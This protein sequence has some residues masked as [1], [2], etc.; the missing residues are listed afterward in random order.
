MQRAAGR[1]GALARRRLSRYAHGHA[2]QAPCRPPPSYPEGR[3]P[4]PEL[5]GL[6]RRGDLTLRL[7]KAALTEWQ[8]PRR[9]TPGGQAWYPDAAIEPGPMLRLVFH[10]ALRQAEGLA[11]SMLR[12]L[13]QAPRVPDHIRLCRR[14]R[15]DRSRA[16]QSGHQTEAARPPLAGP[17]RRSRHGRRG[18]QPHDPGCGAGFHPRCCTQ[19]GGAVLSAHQTSVQQLCRERSPP[20]RPAGCPQPAREPAGCPE[21]GRPSQEEPHR[22]EDQARRTPQKAKTSEIGSVMVRR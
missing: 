20:S 4:V 18:A 6:K 5:A 12:L 17:A 1:Q 13:G 3:L 7:D 8:A 19:L 15:G 14:S 22:G 2:V 10:P 9:T 16:L 11:A 21:E